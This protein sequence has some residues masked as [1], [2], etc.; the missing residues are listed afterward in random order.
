VKKYSSRA[1][2]LFFVFLISTCFARA[3]KGSDSGAKILVGPNLRV[4]LD[5]R[6]ECWIAASKTDPKFLVATSHVAPRGCGT[7]ISRSGGQTWRDVSLPQMVPDCFDIMTTG[8]LDGRVYVSFPGGG[9]GKSWIRVYSTKDQGRTWQGP[10]ELSTPVSP[11]HPRIGVDES[12]GPRRGRVYVEWNSGGDQPLKD[13]YHIFLHYSDDA[14][15][16]F[17]EP[18][19]ITQEVSDGGKLVATEPL[20]LSDGTLLVTYYQYFNPMTGLRNEHQPFYIVRSTDGAK[21][22]AP[23]VKTAELAPSAWR[24]LQRDFGRAFTLPIITAD[25]STTSRFR[26]NI[27]MVWQ[28]VRDGQP[29]IWL[30]RSTDKG[31]T[32]SSPQ[33]LNDNAVPPKDGPVSFR[34]IPVVAVNKDGIVGVAWYDYRDDP[35]GLCWRQYFTASLDG[36]ATFLPNTVVS[37]Q[38]SCPAKGTLSP[39]IYAW[40][41]SPFVHDLETTQEDV[42]RATG[43]QKLMLAMEVS[44]EEAVREHAKEI[45]GA[46]IDITFNKDRNLWPGHYSGLTSDTNGVFHPLWADRRDTVQQLYTAEVEV[47]AAPAPPAPATKQSDVTKLVQVI[48]GPAKHDGQSETTFELQIRNISQQTIYGPL[49]LRATQVLST[50]GG[51]TATFKESDSKDTKALPMWDFSKLLGAKGRLDPGMVSEIKKV[52][53]QTAIAT[54]LDGEFYFEVMGGLTQ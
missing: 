44:S 17:S 1:L 3:Q 14:G 25:T 40:N 2:F 7:V 27:Y 37:D 13:H 42:D 43:G 20:V 22:F 28:D 4:A 41:T 32:W 49:Q 39:S 5:D 12:N 30:I 10:S 24:Y 45:S 31:E 35:T 16:K 38:P 18:I 33:R 52:K 36:G 48:A 53:I 47:T 34:E 6:N 23:P 11:D 46:R 54:G 19:L 51:P 21:T 50:A 15:E 29:Q 8:S 9:N 26:D